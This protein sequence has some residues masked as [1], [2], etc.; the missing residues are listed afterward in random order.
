MIFKPQLPNPS[1]FSEGQIFNAGQQLIQNAANTFGNINGRVFKPIYALENLGVGAIDA[2]LSSIPR[3]AYKPLPIKDPNSTKDQDNWNDNISTR[4]YYQNYKPVYG[5]LVLKALNDQGQP[6]NL[7]N[8]S[9][10]TYSGQPLT[11]LYL[12][13]VL[14]DIKQNKNMPTTR[15]MGHNKEIIEYIG[16][17]S[18]D[19]KLEGTL[20]APNPD[21]VNYDGLNGIFP[22]DQYKMLKN[23]CEM[24]ASIYVLSP[25]LNE[26]F[27]IQYIAIKG[28]KFEQEPGGISYQKYII[29]AKDDSLIDISVLLSPYF[30]N[31]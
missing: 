10:A 28:Y 8:Y 20:L 15:I 23:Y 19:I 18:Y 27:N 12:D 2:Y 24:G 30:N 7:T 6:Y 16:L 9:G 22:V 3:P 14:I 4:T 5:T 1:Q 21:S 11:D 25:T 17:D 26:I 29:E 31:I 13:N